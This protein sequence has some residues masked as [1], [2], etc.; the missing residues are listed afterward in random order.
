MLSRVAERVYWMGRYLERAENTARLINVHHGLLL[1][2]PANAKIG[3]EPILDIMASRDAFISLQ[4]AVSDE[5]QMQSFITSNEK[6]P[7]SLLNSLLQAREN[8]RTT[9][10]L[11]P[12]EAWREVNELHLFAREQLPRELAR[13][14][15]EVLSQIVSRCQTI[16]GLLAGTMSQGAGYQFIRIG[17][18]LERADMTSRLIDV[19]AAV[20]LP[21]RPELERYQNTLWM[22]ILRSAS[23]YQMYRQQ[24]RRRVFGPDV[25]TFLLQD[26]D[27]PRAV[28]HCVRETEK[29][30]MVLPKADSLQPTLN[31]LEAHISKV[32]AKDLDLSGIHDL[33]DRLQMDTSAVHN[34]ISQTWFLPEE[35]AAS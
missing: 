30:V 23:A 34:A 27:F 17:R 5:Q 21:G 10:D 32:A 14:R 4:G 11:L 18:N 28:A 2:L 29:S 22:A 26:V 31:A 12:A 24:V 3:W 9:R 19:A 15:Y 33:M 8:V 6:N 16:S 13:N 20:L 35:R 1:D 25:I 7:S